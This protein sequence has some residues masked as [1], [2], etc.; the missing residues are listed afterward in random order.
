MPRTIKGPRFCPAWFV[1][2]AEVMVRSQCNLKQAAS[3]IGHP[4]DPDEAEKVQ[5]RRDFQD[6]LRIEKNKFF[7]GVANDPSRSKSSAIG[8]MEVLIDCLMREGEYDKAAAAIEKLGKLEGWTGSDSNVNIFAGL[9]ARDIAEAK[10][11]LTGIV[12]DSGVARDIVQPVDGSGARD[13]SN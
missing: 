10:S 11:R 3:E 4:L 2:A 13:L 7:A 9:T 8:K 12:S 6:I 5:R 1:Q